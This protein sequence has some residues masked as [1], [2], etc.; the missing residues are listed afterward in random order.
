[1][2][3]LTVLYD[4]RCELCRRIRSWLETQAA[5]VELEFMPAGSDEAR[6]RFPQL[7][8]AVFCH[9]AEAVNGIAKFSRMEECSR[10]APENDRSQRRLSLNHRRDRVDP[11]P[12]DL[13]S[14]YQHFTG[15]DVRGLRAA[16]YNAAFTSLE[17]DTVQTFPASRLT[18]THPEGCAEGKW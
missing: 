14:R 13:K 16:G 11:I 12:G 7:D 10:V 2:R 3:T 18:G 15:A 1:M 9:R 5:Y 17:E 8:H 6:Y 4:A